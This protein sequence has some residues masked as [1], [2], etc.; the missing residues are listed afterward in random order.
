[1]LHLPLKAA[2]KC[3][4]AKSLHTFVKIAY[5][6]EQADEHRDAF[7]DVA[8]LRERVR[9]VTLTE[10]KAE[11]AVRVVARY[12]RLLTAMRSRFGSLEEASSDIWVAFPWRDA[13]KPAEKTAKADLQF[14]AAAV[15]FNLAAALSYVATVEDRATPTG[16]RAA[17]QAFQHA[18]GALEA[19]TPLSTANL[20]WGA[21][22]V[23]PQA[24]RGW[25]SLMLAQAQQ[26]FYEKAVA[27][28]MKQAV[29][30]KLAAQV[31]A[32][33]GAALSHL[34]H[35]DVRDK[36][37]KWPSVVEGQQRVFE[38]WAQY[39]QSLD[40]EEKYE[41]G[42][43]VARLLHAQWLCQEGCNLLGKGAAAADVKAAAEGALAKLGKA[44]QQAIY[45][46]DSIYHEAVPAFDVLAPIT[47]K[48]IVKS[49]PI[50][51]VLA[52]AA[53]KPSSRR[54]RRGIVVV[55][56]GGEETALW[57]AAARPRAP[58]AARR[59][60]TRSGGSSRCPSSAMSPSTRR[61]SSRPSASSRSGA[62][63]PSSSHW[64]S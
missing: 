26:C 2:D 58:T 14:E 32:S 30:A 8:A 60:T 5:S 20:S 46:N 50:A 15:L 16:L 33:L 4:L 64:R 55:V 13:F 63:T 37:D 28:S 31:G 54:R 35:R 23:H 10:A 40:H 62:T 48:S 12:Y 9:Q 6:A 24:L 45:N 41:Y 42:P 49:A 7:A 29:V 53:A 18:A 52:A 21:A 39:H 43:Q 57:R 3:D 61:A 38:A 34:K 56:G 44:A 51:D 36:F 11:E 59:A 17:C 27:D 25:T 22:D 47:P 19:L 1:M